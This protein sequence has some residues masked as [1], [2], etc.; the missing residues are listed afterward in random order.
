[1]IIV[2]TSFLQFYSLTPLFLLKLC[3]FTKQNEKGRLNFLSE[4]I[5]FLKLV[6]RINNTRYS[7]QKN[8]LPFK[9]LK[10][11][12]IR[13]IL[14]NKSLYLNINYCFPGRALKIYDLLYSTLKHVKPVSYTHLTLPTKRI[15]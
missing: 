10:P 4:R 7:F 3:I 8:R 2:S 9:L 15:V 12:L 1:M 5:I 13:R 14:S 11:H 6:Y